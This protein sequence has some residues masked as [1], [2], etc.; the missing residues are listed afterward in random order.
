MSDDKP[1]SWLD[2]YSVPVVPEGEQYVMLS[3]LAESYKRAAWAEISQKHSELAK[4]LKEPAIKTIMEMFD[5]DLFVEAS[6]AP[7]LPPER[8]KGR[9]RVET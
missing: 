3:G 7:M 4:L 6:K 2:T 5:A 8:L 9:K 1:G